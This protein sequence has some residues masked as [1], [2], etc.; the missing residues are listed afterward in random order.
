MGDDGL[1]KQAEKAGEY[2][3]NAEV[4]ENAKMDELDKYIANT[5]SSTVKTIKFK[6]GNVEYT[7]EEGMSW[8]EWINSE[9]NVDGYKVL[10]NRIMNSTEA[11][12]VEVVDSDRDS[13]TVYQYEIIDDSCEYKLGSSGS[14]GDDAF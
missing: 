10:S 9:Y 14:L 5:I 4:E 11:C 6:I 1:I 12:K 3:L 13:F 2:Q 8:G 7:A